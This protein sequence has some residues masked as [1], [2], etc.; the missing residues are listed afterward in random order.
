MD[1]EVARFISKID[2]VKYGQHAAGK[3]ESLLFRNVLIYV[4]QVLLDPSKKY[5]ARKKKA[6]EYYEN[7]LSRQESYQEAIRDQEL[8]DRTRRIFIGYG[9]LPF[10]IYDE[11][12]A[13]ERGLRQSDILMESL[14]PQREQKTGNRDQKIFYAPK[15][16]NTFEQQSAQIAKELDIKKLPVARGLI[17]KN[18]LEEIRSACSGEFI[19]LAGDIVEPGESL[20]SAL[21]KYSDLK[22]IKP[23]KAYYLGLFIYYLMEKGVL[24]SVD[25]LDHYDETVRIFNKLNPEKK[26]QIE[27]SPLKVPKKKS[28][29]SVIEINVP[30]KEPVEVDPF[31]L[32]IA[33][34]EKDMD[35]DLDTVLKAIQGFNESDEE[36]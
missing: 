27:F 24:E 34:D 28:F 36:T 29:D 16:I 5:G 19:R 13:V 26:A 22:A 23:E 15:A 18:L 3:R 35:T 7:E 31:L 12:A 1:D 6:L 8:R 21:K 10:C 17:Y 2:S 4:I 11:W 20:E 30:K 33:T 14:I 25:F 9:Y 32:S